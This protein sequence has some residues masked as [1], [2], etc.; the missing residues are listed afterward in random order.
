MAATGLMCVLCVWCALTAAGV[1]GQKRV[2]I[3][4]SVK[5]SHYRYTMPA[6]ESKVR[7]RAG[8]SVPFPFCVLLAPLRWRDAAQACGCVGA[9]LW[10]GAAVGVATSWLFFF[11]AHC[12]VSQHSRVAV[13]RWRAPATASRPR[14]PT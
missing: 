11:S 1:Q 10:R 3:P 2:N 12:G 6:I 5:D 4:R 13:C 9:V 14:S 8:C 7:R